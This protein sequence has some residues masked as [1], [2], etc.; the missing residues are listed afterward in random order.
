MVA[1]KVATSAPRYL[2][3]NR[4]KTVA[5]TATRRWRRFD[6]P[7]QCEISEVWGAQ[8]G[9][10]VRSWEQP[11]GRTLRTLFVNRSRAV[12][13][14]VVVVVVVVMVA[15]IFASPII[16][17]YFPPSTSL[18]ALPSDMSIFAGRLKRHG[19]V[20]W[21]VSIV[22]ALTMSLCWYYNADVTNFSVPDA[23]AA[24]VPHM[25]TWDTGRFGRAL[26][27]EGGCTSMDC[28]D[29]QDVTQWN[30][31]MRCQWSFCAAERRANGTA[32]E[33]AGPPGLYPNYWFTRDQR[34]SGAIIVHILILCYMFCG[35]AIICDEYFVPALEVIC[36]QLKLK[37]D[38][39]GATFMAAGGS[40]PEFATSI[41]GVFFSKSDIGFAAIVGSAVFN[42]LFVIG[43]CALVATGVTLTWWPLARDCSYYICSIMLLVICIFDQKIMHFEAILLIL[44]YVGYVVIMKFNEQLEEFVNKQLKVARDTKNRPRWRQVLV[45]V[46]QSWVFNLVIYVTIVLSVLTA[47]LPIV[48]RDV[49][50]E[51]QCGSAE[52]FTASYNQS[53]SYVPAVTEQERIWEVTLFASFCSGAVCAAPPLGDR[54]PPSWGGDI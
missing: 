23:V 6:R 50:P 45:R 42:V 17:V 35:L 10:A 51:I 15:V 9:P 54:R 13:I 22:L 40:A 48:E 29:G 19:R 14:V 41:L 47:F 24:S 11:G 33:G 21:Q 43:G 32:E 38:V 7:D 28:I 52:I 5:H 3:Q 36:E 18:P 39:A 20:R 53:V 44:G 1:E 31:D 8:L 30:D 4:T 2:P 25:P 46:V 16:R 27:E 34:R 37:D 12:I 26:L 49:A